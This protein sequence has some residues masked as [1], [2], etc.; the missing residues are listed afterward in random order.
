MVSVEPPV[1]RLV[2]SV[3]GSYVHV[4]A[5]SLA[6]QCYHVTLDPALR[7]VFGQTLGPSDPVRVEVGQP[8]PRLAIL[9]GDHVIVDPKGVPVLAVRAIGLD[10]VRVRVHTVGP[11]DWTAWQETQRRRWSDDDIKVPGERVAELVLNVAGGR[12][13]MVRRGGRS[14]PPGSTT[15]SASSSCPSSRRIGCRSG[16]GGG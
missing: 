6:G 8:E 11:E 13:V 15:A 16:I 12:A 14:R 7:D 2:A 3:A 9:G 1:E 10:R 5:A 4:T